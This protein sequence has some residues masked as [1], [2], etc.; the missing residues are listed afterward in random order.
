M[1]E[2]PGG[3]QWQAP[4]TNK[5][6]NTKAEHLALYS[7][8]KKY[9]RLRLAL[10]AVYCC[11]SLT[12]HPNKKRPTSAIPHAQGYY[13]GTMGDNAEPTNHKGVR[14]FSIEEA[15]DS[16]SLNM[17]SHDDHFMHMVEQRMEEGK[18]TQYLAVE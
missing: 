8:R 4:Q 2:L 14:L 9:R 11:G 12:A 3:T 17:N 5:Q 16:E 18:R 7:V 10:T 15:I 1:N 13:P 6:T